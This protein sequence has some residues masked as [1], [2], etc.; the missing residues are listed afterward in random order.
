ME[1]VST[2]TV[3]LDVLLVG[4][5]V[6]AFL[7]RPRLGGQMAGGL[8]TLLIGVMILG[9]A[10]LAETAMFVVLHLDASLIEVAHR[11]LVMAGFALVIAGFLAMRRAFER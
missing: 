6:A 4:A 10:H 1:W 5:A 9:L 7:A 11:L 3:V 2:A 8:R